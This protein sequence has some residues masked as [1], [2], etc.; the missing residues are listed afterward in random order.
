MGTSDD[1]CVAVGVASE[2]AVSPEVAQVAACDTS[3]PVE[4]VCEDIPRVV[5]FHGN[6]A[7]TDVLHAGVCGDGTQTI[8]EYEAP[9]E[10][11][12]VT[13]EPK[14]YNTS[15]TVAPT[16]DRAYGDA[17]ADVIVSAVDQ[18]GPPGAPGVPGPRGLRG[19]P[20]PP[21]PA[22]A[23]GPIGPVGPIGPQGDPGQDAD[24]PDAATL[25]NGRMIAV[26][27]GAWVD[28]APPEGM[29]AGGGGSGVTFAQDSQPVFAEENNT[30]WNPLTFQ[31]KVYNGG[32]WQP[33][34]PDGGYF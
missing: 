18:Q 20:G 5:S 30:W 32:Q 14:Y 8:I 24:V 16:D 11:A 28:V 31:M 23:P 12:S 13:V 6:T 10:A 7:S 19:D 3:I 22:G 17:P 26:L 1:I 33:T 4:V 21:G 2:D 27:N 34:A 29:G 25:A 15:V 9:T